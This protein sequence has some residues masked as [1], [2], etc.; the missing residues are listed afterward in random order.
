MWFSEIRSDKKLVDPRKDSRVSRREEALKRGEY[1]A[2]TKDNE[3]V[4]LIRYGGK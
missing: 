4:S 3:S 2:K 1:N